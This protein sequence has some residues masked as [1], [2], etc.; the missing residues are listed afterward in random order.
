MRKKFAASILAICLTLG[1]ASIQAA[2]NKSP[3]ELAADT[4]EY[5]SAQG[6]AIAQGGVRIT[7]GQAV[8]TG[9][10]AQYNS[11]TGEVVLVGG[12]K[13]VQEQT[14]LTA[15]EVRSVS[16]S[17]IIATG[18]VVLVKDDQRLTGS[19]LDYYTDKNYALLSGGARIVSNEATMTARQIES[20]IAENRTTGTGGVHIVSDTH[21]VDATADQAAYTINQK[22]QGEIVLSG[23]ARA[24]QQG[25]ILTGNKLTIYLGDKAVS[26]QGRTK[27]VITPQ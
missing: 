21:Q 18:Q 5:D 26:S 12:V 19:K 1:M 6:I 27:L 7:Q 17:H 25:N 24:V 8:M 23:N 16:S 11:N 20:W 9:T 10:T 14:T 15:E 3:V 13:V 2:T 4:I 22:G